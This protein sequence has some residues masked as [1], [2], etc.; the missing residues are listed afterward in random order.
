MKNKLTLIIL[1]L[2]FILS[3]S[4]KSIIIESRTS[5]S[6]IDGKKTIASVGC[7]SPIEEVRINVNSISKRILAS[8]FFIKRNN[9]FYNF[10]QNINNKQVNNLKYNFKL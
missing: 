8:I 9:K 3:N 6:G 7:P 5:V 10:T 4:S 1:T 2:Y